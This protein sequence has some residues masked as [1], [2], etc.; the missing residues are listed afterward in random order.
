[1]VYIPILSIRPAEVIALSELPDFSKDGMMPLILIKPW[2]G[3]G[4]LS[5]GLDKIL[6]GFPSRAWLAEL[7]PEYVASQTSDAFAEILN[8]RDSTDGFKNWIDFVGAMPNAIP[9]LQ[10]RGA[11]SPVEILKQIDAASALG[12]G[13]CIRIERAIVPAAPFIDVLFQRKNTDVTIIIDYGQQDARLLVNAIPAQQDVKYIRARIPNAEIALSSTTFPSAFS[14]DS[15]EIYER[16]F[17]DLVN[18]EVGGLVFSDRGSARAIE[19]GGGGVP[20]PRIDLPTS[21]RWHFFRSDCVRAAG[22]SDD[23]FRERRIE[24]YGDMADDAVAN[25][26]W[27]ST[28]NIWGTQL[29]KITQLRSPFGINSPAK[30]TACRIN[31]H[32]ARQ[33][34]YG[35]DVS[36]AELEEDWVD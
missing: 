34:F 8:L 31:I 22:E 16:R 17:F 7:D 3:T 4:G 36:S 11:N 29:I 12:R 6:H 28:L 2:L 18:E 1:M 35:R 25:T 27:D 5:R 19:Q 10:L 24:A 13:I 32:L 21:S 33:S 20:R 14:Q 30:A 26:A 15:Q 9:V 23:D